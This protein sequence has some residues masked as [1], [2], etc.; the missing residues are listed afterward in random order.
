MSAWLEAGTVRVSKDYSSSGCG[1]T[2]TLPGFSLPCGAVCIELY[3][4]HLLGP[5]KGTGKVFSGRW[6]FRYKKTVVSGV[7]G[8]K[9]QLYLASACMQKWLRSLLPSACWPS[10]FMGHTKLILLPGSLPL[11]ASPGAACLRS[12]YILDC[13][14]QASACHLLKVSTLITRLKTTLPLSSDPASLSFCCT[15]L[16]YF[17]Y[18]APL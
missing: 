12:A 18:Y 1:R 9:N 17:L 11:C 10:F 2:L 4:C 13:L 3:G 8:A 16:P 7:R 6:P 14:N 5:A 15:T